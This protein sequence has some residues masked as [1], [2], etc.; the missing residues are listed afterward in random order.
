MNTHVPKFCTD[1]EGSEDGRSIGISFLT[2][3]LEGSS[4]YH[5]DRSLSFPIV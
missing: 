2:T 1:F 4:L 5:F 3:E